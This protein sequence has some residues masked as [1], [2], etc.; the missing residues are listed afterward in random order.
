[1]R[2]RRDPAFQALPP[3]A[4]SGALHE[5]MTDLDFKPGTAE[6]YRHQIEAFIKERNPH[7]D[8]FSLDYRELIAQ[9]TKTTVSRGGHLIADDFNFDIRAY[10]EKL[11]KKK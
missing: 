7:A 1:M 6:S 8:V 4:K 5:I 10:N 3:A 11:A 2:V 9:L